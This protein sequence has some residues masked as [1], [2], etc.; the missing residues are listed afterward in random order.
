MLSDSLWFPTS[1][2]GNGRSSSCIDGLCTSYFGSLFLEPSCRPVSKDLN[3]ELFPVS[4]LE[5][6]RLLGFGWSVQFSLYKFDYLDLRRHSL[7]RPD[8]PNPAEDFP[9]RSTDCVKPSWRVSSS[10]DIPN[11]VSFPIKFQWNFFELSFPQKPCE[12]VSIQIPFEKY[13]RIFNVDPGFWPLMSWKTYP[14]VWTFWFCNS[15]QS[16]SV[17]QFHLGI[18]WYRVG[19]LSVSIKSSCNNVHYFCGSHLW[20]RR[21]LQSRL[22]Q[23][24]HGARLYLC[25][26]VLWDLTPRSWGGICPSM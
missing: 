18:G 5:N 25:I 24:H 20:R 3:F 6:F 10:K 23:C 2:V 14:W 9:S 7:G 8:V 11:S 17:L 16:R 21:G 1:F 15:D 12:W 22:L 4:S 26:F 13:H 19:C